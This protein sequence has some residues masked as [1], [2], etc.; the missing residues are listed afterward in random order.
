LLRLPYELVTIEAPWADHKLVIL[1]RQCVD[2][3][4]L[5]LWVS[6]PP[7]KTWDDM[8]ISVVINDQFPRFMVIGDSPASAGI[9]EQTASDEMSRRAQCAVV[10]LI[11]LL[12]CLAARGTEIRQVRPA[13]EVNR[14]RR[15]RRLAPIKE[16]RVV[17][18]ADRAV[19]KDSLGNSRG[20]AP[21][22]PHLR[23]GHIRNLSNGHQVWIDAM[24]VGDASRGVLTHEYQVSKNVRLASSKTHP[25]HLIA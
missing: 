12:S 22:R 25:S 4:G 21:P 8:S 5:R 3:I 2:G 1:A 11:V 6:K 14:L 18:I 9:D 17:K 13:Q 15:L 20:H 24:I 10:S 7:F 16:H 19:Y 23:R